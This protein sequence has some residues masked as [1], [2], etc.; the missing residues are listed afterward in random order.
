MEVAGAV[1]GSGRITGTTAAPRA[2]LQADLASIDLGK[3]LITP[4]HLQLSFAKDGQE[5]AGQAALSGPTRDGPAQARSRFR[6]VPKGLDL[7]ELFAQAGGV[8]LAGSLALRDGAPSRA[9]LQVAAGPG[10]FLASGRLD[11]AVKI[12]ARSGGGSTAAIHL[13]GA[14]LSLPGQAAR[15]STLQL[16]ADGPLE[17]LPLRLSLSAVAPVAASFA[18]TGLLTQTGLG[19]GATRELSLSGAGVARGLDYRTLQPA[20]LT[21]GPDG[22]AASLRLAVADGRVSLDGR[23]SPAGALHAQGQAVGVSLSTVLDDYAGALDATLQLDGQ[24]PRLSGRVDA[25]ISDARTRDAPAGL[26]LD[27]VLHA[28]LAD[29]RLQLQAQATNRQGL[30]ASTNLDLPAVAAADPFRLALD[31]TR[32]IGG[33]FSADGELKPLWDLLAGGERTLS[34]RLTAHGTWAGT[35]DAP[36]PT[37]TIAI[38][39][40]RF[41]DSSTGLVLEKLDAQAALGRDRVDV[42]RF[43]GGDGRGG[44]LSGSGVVSLTPSGA[45]SFQIELTKF[46]LLDNELGR[47]I[48]SGPVTVV[49]DA[50]GKARVVGKLRIVHAEITTKTPIPT[51]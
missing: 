3:L 14:D 28:R 13:T 22:Q 27:A 32:P 36:R 11:G 26:A 8:R 4:A 25:H 24:G 21:L 39:G 6:F 23:R 34:G 16:S 48:A 1:K 40:G 41:A 35:L 51:A 31:R 17:R 49:R 42:S 12:D 20:H 30:R 43:S 50:Q 33:D 15:I 45:S 46:Q 37:G 44:V 18:G 10:V 47:A 19:A 9:D 5:L 29:S 38:S 7:D 2:E